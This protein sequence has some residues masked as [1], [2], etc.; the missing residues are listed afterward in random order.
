MI[1]VIVQLVR[2]MATSIQE[3]VLS[4]LRMLLQARSAS[5]MGH[6]LSLNRAVSSRGD[7]SQR[8]TKGCCRIRST[9]GCSFSRLQDSARIKTRLASPARSQIHFP[10]PVRARKAGRQ[11]AKA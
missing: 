2:A 3:L 8:C 9:A 11:I 10:F 4:R 1:K 6:R 5:E 7:S